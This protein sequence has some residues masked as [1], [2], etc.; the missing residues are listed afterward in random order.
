MAK[1]KKVGLA[2]GS[3]GVRGLVHIGV[4][5]TLLAHHIPIDIIAGTSAGSVIGGSFIALQDIGKIETIVEAFGYRDL[6]WI[7]TDAAFS[8]GINKGQRAIEF[9][10]HYIGKR[11]IESLVTP[12]A[13]VATDI[14]T[15]EPVIITHGDLL[16]AM[17]ASSS[18]P[19]LFQPIKI[20]NAYLMDGG[21]SLPVPVRVVK[22]MGADIII[23]VSCDAHLINKEANQ[24]Q[25]QPSALSIA[26]STMNSL[27]YSLAKENVKSA[28]IVIEPLVTPKNITESV[29]GGPTIQLG[30]DATLKMLPA[31]QK[32]L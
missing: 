32:L 4:I 11:T 18:V 28:D 26:W 14:A 24:Q 3:G 10:Q 27:R 25:N 30:V 1:Q 12:F 5:K 20:G 16:T 6:A 2:L 9:L 15:G 17:R 8:S 31:I 7:L 22:K 23:A 21:T 19:L 13:A 29:H